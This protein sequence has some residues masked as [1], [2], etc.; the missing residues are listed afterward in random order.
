[1][2]DREV[3]LLFP[4]DLPELLPPL[5]FPEEDEPDELW[6]VDP[7]FSFLSFSCAKAP[8]TRASSNTAI[9]THTLPR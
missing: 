9:A 5:D 7:C 6:L 1:M 4:D 3:E 2:F 8:A